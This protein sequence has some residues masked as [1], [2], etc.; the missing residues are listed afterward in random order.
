M[1][2]HD[3]DNEADLALSS[4]T[5]QAASAQSAPGMQQPQPGMQQPQPGMQQPQPDC[6]TGQAQEAEDYKDPVDVSCSILHQTHN[7][8]S[9]DLLCYQT[10]SPDV[11][12]GC[13]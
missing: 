3:I 2:S 6:T 9:G 10:H 12:L 1:F 11:I 8:N 7:L 5:R 13:W 4:G